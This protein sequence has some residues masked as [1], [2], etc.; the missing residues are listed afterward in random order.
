MA[1]SSAGRR[2]RA[3]SPGA[4]IAISS[5][6]IIA[7]AFEEQHV[8]GRFTEIV[9]GVLIIEDLIGI[10]LIAILTTVATGTA[11]SASS[12]AVTGAR[13]A[14][15]LAG[16]IGV[17]LLVVPRTIR[18]VVRM[19]RPE[20]TLVASIGICFAAA[21]LALSFGYSVALG[22][23]IAGS[24]VAESG[25]EKVVEHLV[26]PVRDVF[27]AIFFV[28]VGVLIDPAIV[29][30]HW[31]AVLAFSVAVILGKLVFVT[32]SSFLTG[33]SPRTSVQAGMSLAQIGEFSFIIAGV[34]L[35]SGATRDFLYPVAVAVSAITTLTTPW[36]IRAAGPVAAWV[37]RKLPPPLQ[38]FVSLYGSWIERMRRSGEGAPELS[39]TRRLVRLL[40]LDAV[41]I[42]AI[43][44]G[45][46]LE[47]GRS[48]ALIHDS[49][50]LSERLARAVVPTVAAIIGLPLLIGLTRT[51]R[52]LG[53]ALAQKAIPAPKPGDVDVGAAPR[54]ALVVTLQLAILAVIAIPIVA[55]TL[56]FLP[57]YRYALVPL[58]LVAIPAVAF[59]RS[60]MNLQGHAKAGAEIIAMKIGS[61]M[62]DAPA[63]G[64]DPFATDMERVRLAL[65]GL[66]DPVSVR[67]GESSPASDL[68]LAELNLRGV[69]G[70]TV[71]AILR[72]GEQVL[73][74][75]GHDRVRKGDVLAVAG[76]EE[77]V[78][79]AREL[80]TGVGA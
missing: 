37:D 9:F 38:T 45:A 74:P 19:N 22:A 14:T 26:Q 20:T 79:A 72:D 68:T 46:S 27:A 17:G 31:G 48:A 32:I 43:V 57:S 2:S 54:R 21:L 18:A 64:D 12:L 75:S 50:G 71:L 13:L 47:A 42:I 80:L 16:L 34:G 70:A 8:K 5:T 49:I 52:H 1:S 6:T 62:A 73:V 78:A 29:A 24:L 4:V 66:G 30:Q 41:L 51:A 35:A 36:L 28:S 63:N 77:S 23:F 76:S 69:T 67:I 15:F 58:A 53:V 60:A 44:I 61:G 56:P 7:K 55:I 40:L 59:W 3:C 39:A 25:E 11:V 33:Y 10:F 65:P